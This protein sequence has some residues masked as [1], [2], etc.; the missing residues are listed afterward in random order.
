MES[1]NY[2]VKALKNALGNA[3]PQ[4]KSVDRE[5]TGGD[6]QPWSMKWKGLNVGDNGVQA[7]S[8]G[9]PADPYYFA[10]LYSHMGDRQVIPDFDKMLHTPLGNLELSSNQEDYNSVGADFYPNDRTQGYIQALAKL[11]G[12]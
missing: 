8:Y 6:G 7:G 2:Y 3:V 12:R 4:Y 1:G 5:Y 11:L 9:P 10:N